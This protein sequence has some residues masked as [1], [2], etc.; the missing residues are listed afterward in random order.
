MLLALPLFFVPWFI[1]SWSSQRIRAHA[2]K[3]FQLP[4]LKQDPRGEL[5][6]AWVQRTSKPFL[7]VRTASY[8][9]LWK[10][11]CVTAH[12]K[13]LRMDLGTE[14]YPHPRE[15][16]LS[17]Q[18]CFQSEPLDIM[19]DISGK[20]FQIAKKGLCLLVK[21]KNIDFEPCKEGQISQYFEKVTPQS[22]LDSYNEYR[23]RP[24]GEKNL[25]LA[26][27]DSNQIIFGN[28]VTYFHFRDPLPL[29][30]I[31]RPLLQIPSQ[32]Q[33][34]KAYDSSFTAEKKPSIV[35]IAIDSLREDIVNPFDM[36][37][38]YEFKQKSKSLARSFSGA[39]ATYHSF[40]SLWN[41]RPAYEKDFYDKN[42]LRT[43]GSLFFNIL[44][45]LGY[46]LHIFGQL[47]DIFDEG[48]F[49]ERRSKRTAQM[50]EKQH[51]LHS[52]VFTD[53]HDSC[54]DKHTF[55]TVNNREQDQATTESFVRFMADRVKNKGPELM[56]VYFAG[57]H[58]PYGV[59]EDFAA[60]LSGSLR[61]PAFFYDASQTKN[62]IDEHWRH[63]YYKP[64][65]R[66]KSYFNSYANA[67]RFADEQ[68]ASILN[69]LK[70]KGV[71]EESIIMILGDHGETLGENN[72]YGHGGATEHKA[73]EIP[74]YY[75]FP[76]SF[77]E[78]K[79]V[80]NTASTMDIVPTL[81]ETMTV[82]AL[83]PEVDIYALFKGH[84]IYNESKACHLSV[85]P[86]NL[87]HAIEFSFLTGEAKLRA[88]F[89]EKQKK[90]GDSPLPL[91]SEKLEPIALTDYFDK[92]LKI[93]PD[94]KKASADIQ[95][96]FAHC[97]E[98]Y[99]GMK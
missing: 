34:D 35:L 36:P 90:Q 75:H 99:F 46:E 74:L 14:A 9:Q 40:F 56:A 11:Q 54:S 22:S 88:R 4:L 55:Q 19:F 3:N 47:L 1:V 96:R 30:P 65:Q 24:L 37:T 5:S 66:K 67:A 93:D 80:A 52:Q 39:T 84:S 76:A 61:G 29:I 63:W 50:E 48:L 21:D 92:P 45:K 72:R 73:T 71:F 17:M 32:A 18:D 41:S 51:C 28:Q 77:E 94:P 87:L 78:R 12:E 81:L 98:H 69:E 27:D 26:V 91:S 38:L 7:L 68:I 89:R 8:H 44:A 23:I 6:Y 64:K 42:D 20:S 33:M 43:K 58:S 62:E 49:L 82:E 2:L 15:I 13:E 86:N 25:W 60:N 57:L 31:P 83:D 53:L 16:N 85:S 70:R 97:F 59:S 95:S 79:I 10:E